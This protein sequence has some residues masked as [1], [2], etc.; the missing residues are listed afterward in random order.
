MGRIW[1]LVSPSEL[2]ETCS[3]RA[4]LRLPLE[5]T[6]LQLSW[7]R[8]LARVN[9]WK[10]AEAL[11]PLSR[12]LACAAILATATSPSHPVRQR[13]GRVEAGTSRLGKAGNLPS[14]AALPGSSPASGSSSQHL[15]HVYGGPGDIGPCG[16]GATRPATGQNLNLWLQPPSLVA[17]FAA[18]PAASTAAIGR[19]RLSARVDDVTSTPRICQRG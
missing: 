17:C 16:D 8:F 19:E 1:R 13:L 4:V 5:P 3:R 2:G 10:L 12:C 9:R 11:G 14:L 6:S 18:T 7:N 15:S